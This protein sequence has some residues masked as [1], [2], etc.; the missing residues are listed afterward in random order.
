LLFGLQRVCEIGF[1]AIYTGAKP[2]IAPAEG[3]SPWGERLEF[4]FSLAG[5]MLRTR[6]PVFAIIHYSSVC[7]TRTATGEISNAFLALRVSFNS[8]PR[9]PSPS[10]TR[11]L[12][13]GAF[14][15]IPPADTSVSNPPN[16]AANASIHFFYLV[17]KQRYRLDCIHL[18][19]GFYIR[20]AGEGARSERA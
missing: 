9:N 3:T 14:F 18:L 15:P 5:P 13:K 20:H 12:I 1:T 19:R 17:I 16:D 11:A 6:Q 7:K 8:T 4:F 2:H 10:Q